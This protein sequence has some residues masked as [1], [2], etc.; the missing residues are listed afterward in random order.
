[1]N[2]NKHEH[3]KFLQKTNNPYYINANHKQKRDLLKNIKN[4]Y[5]KYPINVVRILTMD[6]EVARYDSKYVPSFGMF[7][8]QTDTYNCVSDTDFN[9]NGLTIN[10]IPTLSAYNNLRTLVCCHSKLIIIPE[11]PNSL[12]ELNI[13]ANKLSTVDDLSYLHNLTYF[14]CSWNKELK[15][16]PKLPTG[17]KYLRALDCGLISLSNKLPPNLNELFVSSNCIEFFPLI[18]VGV[19]IDEINEWELQENPFYDIFNA[20]SSGYGDIYE[21]NEIMAK[22]NRFKF[23]YYGLKSIAKIKFYIWEKIRIKVEQKYHPSV[24][25][26]LANIN[27]DNT[28]E[29]Y[30]QL[31]AM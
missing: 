1:M 26:E 24:I 8:I 12:T 10:Y 15:I 16:L 28:D 27:K 25:E 21:V 31:D 11:L 23:L 19:N 20:N 5:S 7:N 22:I 29:F 9:K 2:F 4:F 14:D 30:N 13:S 6:K 18:K 3:R 17:L